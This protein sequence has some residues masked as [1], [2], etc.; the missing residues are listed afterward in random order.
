MKGAEFAADQVSS[1]SLL[2]HKSLSR[3]VI[4]FRAD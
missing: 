4:N 3:L 1:C 2:I